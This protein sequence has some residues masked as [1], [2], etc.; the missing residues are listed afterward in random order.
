MPK[1][2]VNPIPPFNVGLG[3]MP[4]GFRVKADMHQL[5][6]NPAD[7]IPKDFIAEAKR[8][9]KYKELVLD[10]PVT[11]PRHPYF[12]EY[13]WTT[14]AN[15]D[16][17]LLTPE[18]KYQAWFARSVRHA[19]AWQKIGALYEDGQNQWNQWWLTREAFDRM[20]NEIVASREARLNIAND[21]WRNGDILPMDQRPTAA[22]DISYLMPYMRQVLDEWH[23][24]QSHV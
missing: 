7:G 17:E 2:F 16:V 1:R 6:R 9:G 12:T 19:G 5:I 24:S 22:E 8:A 15:A 21:A 10:M 23:E 18:Q 13:L 3:I 11:D 4:A 14:Y 20:P